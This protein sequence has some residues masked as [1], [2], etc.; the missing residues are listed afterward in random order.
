M[1]QYIHGRY[2]DY[3]RWTKKPINPKF[4]NILEEANSFN[5]I[6]DY[7]YSLGNFI[8]WDNDTH[9]MHHPRIEFYKQFT[10][11]IYKK[12]TKEQNV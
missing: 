9:G 6:I 3:K 5:S 7:N 2:D 12:L 4:V 8:H 1:Q 10:D 11:H